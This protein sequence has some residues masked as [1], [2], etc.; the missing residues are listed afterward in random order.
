MSAIVKS[1]PNP[2]TLGASVH[3]ERKHFLVPTDKP[4][5]ELE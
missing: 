3:R 1:P 4:T 2:L 5:N